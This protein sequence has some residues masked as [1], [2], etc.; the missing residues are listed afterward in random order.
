MHKKKSDGILFKIDFEKA[1]DKVK[2]PF[3]LK[4]LEMKG[5]PS[6]FNDWIMKTVTTGKVGIK[7]NDEIG[8][9][10][11]TYQGPR[12]GDPLSPLLFDAIVDVLSILVERVQNEGLLTSLC[13]DF[14]E[15]GIAILQYADDTIL[16]L[17][18]NL[19]QARNLKILLCLF[20]QMTGLKINFHKSEIYFL[21]RAV[22]RKNEFEEIITFC[23]GVL[24]MKYL[25][26][27]IDEKRIRN[28]DWKPAENKM[29]SKL[30]CW[31]GKGL[32]MGGK[33]SL[34]NS[35]L[36]SIPLYMLSFYILP[37]GPKERMDMHRSR[38][39][40][41]EVKGKKKYHLVS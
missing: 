12:Q 28:I 34:I 10:F 16:L 7:V 3:L 11:N 18:N 37:K 29:E 35:S 36:S 20:E 39:L 27:P 31:Q 26:V 2:W 13:T 1:F 40:W 4:V 17:Q 32:A 38:L 14:A 25:G 8:S 23:S 24:P 41:E 9:Y 5:F 6:V 21:G 19:Y 22:E 15:K 33:I 30:Q